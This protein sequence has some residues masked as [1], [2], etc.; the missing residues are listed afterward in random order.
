MCSGNWH[1]KEEEILIPGYGLV[2]HNDRSVNSG[3][4]LIGVRDNKKN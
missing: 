1:A 2:Y 4:I 3:G